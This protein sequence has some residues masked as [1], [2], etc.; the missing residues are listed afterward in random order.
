MPFRANFGIAVS[1]EPWTGNLHPEPC[2]AAVQVGA[3]AGA[4][5]HLPPGGGTAGGAGEAGE[6]GEAG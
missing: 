5:G 2:V 3:A 4:G 6:A 1:E